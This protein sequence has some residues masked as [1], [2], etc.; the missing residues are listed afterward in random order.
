MKSG[1]T[2]IVVIGGGGAVGA[3]VGQ[4]VF[5]GNRASRS[6]SGGYSM[7]RNTEP[8]CGGGR[9]WP[10]AM[11]SSLPRLWAGVAWF[12]IV[13]DDGAALGAAEDM[14]GGGVRK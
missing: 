7:T 12:P 4:F 8:F 2:R 3:V 5:A 11:A 10:R 6:V 1:V 9:R 13:L 14:R